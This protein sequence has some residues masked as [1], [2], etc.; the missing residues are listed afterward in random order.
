LSNSSKLRDKR[1]M[2]A[3]ASFEMPVS[4]RLGPG[5]F[6][7]QRWYDGDEVGVAAALADA[8]E[9]PLDLA[10]ARLDSGQ[11]VRHRLARIV[12]GVDAEP[13]ARHARG[14]HPADD[15]AHLRRLRAAVG[16]AKHDP[17]RAGVISSLRAGQRIIGV[18]LVAVEEM[19]A[20]QHDLLARSGRC[21]DRGRDRFQILLVGA[22]QRHAHV[23]V[24]A[25]RHEADGVGL[26]LQQRGQPRIVGGRMPARLTMPKATKDE[27]RV[28]FSAK[29]AVSVGLA[30]G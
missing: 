7:H 1:V 15:L 9:R 23:I 22:A 29:K 14:D 12:V 21:L 4:K 24:P 17:A 18:G 8:V 27:R 2:P 20:V 16:V 3:S 30:P 6:Q 13:V 10:N 25:F 26:R 5:W 11:R 28:R 19:L